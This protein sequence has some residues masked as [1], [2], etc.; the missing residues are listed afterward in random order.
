MYSW[1]R[2]AGVPPE[3]VADLAETIFAQV[4]QRLP[5]CEIDQQPGGFRRWLWTITRE[6]LSQRDDG[7]GA[8]A[9]PLNGPSLEHPPVMAGAEP[10]TLLIAAAVRIVKSES[11][12]NTWDAFWRTAVHGEQAS[13]IAVDLGTTR[14]AV[15]AARFQVTRKLRQLLADDLEELSMCELRADA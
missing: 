8:H 9:E 7:K 13:E 6:Q 14:R 15:R 11:E 3:Q 10:R 12:S 1:G 5:S 4:R 2:A